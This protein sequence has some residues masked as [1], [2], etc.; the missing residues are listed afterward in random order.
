MGDAASIEAQ[1]EALLR[2]KYGG[3]KPKKKLISQGHGQKYFDSGDWVLQ[4]QEQ[5]V[6]VPGSTRLAAASGP[7][8]VGG[9]GGAAPEPDRDALQPVTTTRSSSGTDE[10]SKSPLS[11]ESNQLMT[12]L[13]ED[14]F[15]QS[16]MKELLH[17]TFHGLSSSNV[18]VVGL[19]TLYQKLTS[20]QAELSAPER[21]NLALTMAE[22]LFFEGKCAT[23]MSPSPCLPREHAVVDFVRR[24]HDQK[25]SAADAGV[26]EM[27]AAG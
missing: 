19:Y 17:G 8:G 4:K 22:C 15:F 7:T 20:P 1:Q 12:D 11:K 24:L 25:G 18:A 13:P 16:P 27:K 14:S 26:E 5:K 3:I 6:P 2:S 10:R 23:F 21:E 9:K